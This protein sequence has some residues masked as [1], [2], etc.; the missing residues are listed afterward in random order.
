M[1]KHHATNLVD[2]FLIDTPEKRKLFK[3]LSKKLFSRVLE[4]NFET[5]HDI[6]FSISDSQVDNNQGRAVSAELYWFV[7]SDTDQHCSL[8]SD[9]LCC[10]SWLATKD[11][12]KWFLEANIG[13]D[14]L[15]AESKA[16]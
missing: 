6:H 3:S 11:I 5:P 9:T 10:Y 16:A 1:P 13:L 7:N 15:V 2:D 14:L 12:E 4:L 8:D